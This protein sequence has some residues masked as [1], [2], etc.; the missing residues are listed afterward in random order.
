M[1]AAQS[2]SLVAVAVLA[3]GCLAACGGAHHPSAKSP[4]S[5]ASSTTTATIAPPSPAEANIDTAAS[6]RLALPA[7]APGNWNPLAAGGNSQATA[8]ISA[9]VLPSVFQLQPN[10]TYQL[11]TEFVTSATETDQPHQVVVY[12]L[13]PKATWSD[14]VPITVNDFVYTWQAQSGNAKFKDM[15][16]RPFSP[17]STL[18][19][20]R[21]ARWERAP[22]TPIR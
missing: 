14:G 9:G 12:H 3:S 15:G 2:A 10:S 7:S 11:N 13:N 1:G 6:L 19:Y 5:P 8:L 22:A 21:S 16:G 20:R 17:A 4:P 18:G